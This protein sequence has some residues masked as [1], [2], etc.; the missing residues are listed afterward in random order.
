[1]I[2]SSPAAAEPLILRILHIIPTLEGGGAERQLS[3]LAAEQARRG[4]DVH[5]AVRRTGVHAQT[6]RNSGV[7]VHELGNLRS[8]DPRL[9]LA[10]KCVIATVRPDIVQTWLPQ[11]DVLGGAAIFSSR[12]PWIISERT[13]GGY[14]RTE[15]PAFA[16]L[17]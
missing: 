8:F 13:S 10:L 11:M 17:R 3:M 4:H 6:T 1:M 2:V 12:I 16:R 15:I 7:R 5:V 14:Y 9:F